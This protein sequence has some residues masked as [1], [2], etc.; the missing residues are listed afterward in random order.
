[1]AVGLGVLRLEPKAFWSMTLREIEAALHGLLGTSG[2]DE[3]L[4][5][6]ELHRL[7][8]RFPDE[9]LEG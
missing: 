6:D 9:R 1:M 7:M 8:S 5:R 2:A 4:K 3:T